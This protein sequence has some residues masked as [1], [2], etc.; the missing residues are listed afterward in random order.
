MLSPSL[1]IIASQRKKLKQGVWLKQMNNYV[2]FTLFNVIHDITI[3][4][5]DFWEFMGYILVEET[6]TEVFRESSH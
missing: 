4:V 1:V 6:E 2:Q 5:D 3:L